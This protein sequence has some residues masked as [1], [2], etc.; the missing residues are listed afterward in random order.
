ML[1]NKLIRLFKH[2]LYEVPW[3]R[4]I[5]LFLALQILETAMFGLIFVFA[6]GGI[7]ASTSL[8][9]LLSVSMLW[10]AVG[11]IVKM[12]V[13]FPIWITTFFGA[14]WRRNGVSR[15]DSIVVLNLVSAVVTYALFEQFLPVSLKETEYLW[16]LGSGVAFASPIALY[17]LGYPKRF[18]LLKK[19]TKR[20]WL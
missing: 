2:V 7:P 16:L 3:E 4:Y 5:A 11:G 14:L 17:Y 20:E 9:D 1:S 15:I 18:L 13:S 8:W 12:V 19:A 10:I 6:F